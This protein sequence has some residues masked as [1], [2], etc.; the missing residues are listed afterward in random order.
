MDG[1]CPLFDSRVMLLANRDPEIFEFYWQLI[2]Y[3]LTGLG[4]EQKFVFMHGDK[5]NEGKTTFTSVLGKLFGSYARA[6]NNK[7]FVKTRYEQ[8]FNLASLAGRSYV[9]SNEIEK[10]EEFASARLKE[11]TGG[12]ILEIERKGIDAEEIP[13]TWMLWF[14]GNYLPSFPI[15][16]PGLQR[17][18]LL[19][20][21]RIPVPTEE[22]RPGWADYVFKEE[23]AGIFG[24][25]LAY[26]QAYIKSPRLIVP[27]SVARRV[28]ESFL[29]GDTFWQFIQENCVFGPGLK[30]VGQELFDA[31]RRWHDKVL[32]GRYPM[33]R[34]SF[35]AMV[36]A[37]SELQKLGVKKAK[38]DVGRSTVGQSRE[39]AHGFTG[40]ALGSPSGTAY[41]DNLEA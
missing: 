22:D 31:Y 32:V 16:D 5:G 40:I 34:T 29:A 2:G 11:G 12:G 6:I 3:S 37:H 15:N 23:G 35:Y 28:N 19:L 30:V 24:K 1:C 27:Q 17:R 4:K 14:T 7:A 38:L 25:A 36:E 39:R 21:P 18:M 10:G 41:A 33:G 8:R 26:R 20:E 9:F 13:V